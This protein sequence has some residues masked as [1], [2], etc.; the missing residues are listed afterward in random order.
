[1]TRT[2]TCL[3]LVACLASLP[4]S[5]ARGQP[6]GSTGPR[7]ER[8]DRHGAPLPAA[9]IA[10]L[11]K[12]RPD[13]PCARPFVAFAPDGKTVVT[14]DDGTGPVVWEAATGKEVRSDK[15]EKRLGANPLALT[16]DGR[17][18]AV[19][20]NTRGIHLWEPAT[21]NRTRALDRQYDNGIFC[22]ALSP[23]ARVLAL[24]GALGAPV[25]LIDTAT[26]K[27]LRSI[28]I[29]R[30]V[31]ES[32]AF[33]PDG[34]TLAA[35]GSDYSVRLW[36]AATGELLHRW[37]TDAACSCLAFSPDGKTLAASG[38]G[39]AVSLWDVTTG[40]LRRGLLGKTGVGRSLA[41]SPEG[42]TLALGTDGRFLCVWEV[43]SG[44]LVRRFD[45]GRGAVCGVAFSPD[46]RVLASGGQDGST[47]L[48]DLTGTLEGH[49]PAGELSAR[50]LEELWDALA[51]E[52]DQAYQAGWTLALKPSRALPFLTERVRALAAPEERIAQLIND[53]DSPK[54]PVRAR[55]SG[56]L[57]RIGFRAAA[58]LRKALQGK[59]SAE[60]RR[61]A[62]QLLRRLEGEE[63][64]FQKMRLVRLVGV[65][66]QLDA[67]EGR[68]LLETLAREGKEP[69]LAE[70]A[71]AAL[72]RR[73]GRPAPVLAVVGPPA[74]REPVD[75][76]P[77]K[78]A[79]SPEEAVL[80]LAEAGRAE[81][82]D[83]VV[84]QFA[85]THR[86]CVKA[87]LEML[88][89]GEAFEDVL[90]RKLGKD[91]RREPF[92]R[93][94]SYLRGFAEFEVQDVKFKGRRRAELTVWDRGRR[95]IS[96]HTWAAVKEGGGWRL[97]IPLGGRSYYKEEPR[98][99]GPNQ[100]ANVYVITF[101]APLEGAEVTAL[102]EGYRGTRAALEQ[103]TRD[104]NAGRFKSRDEVFKA[105][106][107]A[108]R[109]KSP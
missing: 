23:D 95:T 108:P 24:G 58:A 3:V 96:E 103:V 28:P 83:G 75:P 105:L 11:G 64:S 51:D 106:D 14:A 71:R 16:A 77:G 45:G 88:R 4:G 6:P 86:A 30:C 2:C 8:T 33:A 74:G 61:R 97:Q 78:P 34:K 46:G 72:R 102:T 109:K 41:F 91:P 49:V 48:W 35:G 36:N 27:R 92:Y 65:L 67:P 17:T 66:E 7:R 87:R 57:E 9:A 100:F 29:T 37:Q 52:A 44:E 73:V 20:V 54:F 12:V 42:K 21:G 32:I 38:W 62:E 63:G 68:T 93:F 50:R 60:V 43:A 15:G 19:L 76:A 25:Q 47:L 70:E 81:D 31:V 26:S 56:E 85:G 18:L 89:A 22:M 80:L 101:E 13:Q 84:G 1:M 79:A 107:A 94:K 82:V 90:D 10:R 40:D 5:P 99:T 69:W 59:P 55:A 53:L 104:I 98:R 39:K